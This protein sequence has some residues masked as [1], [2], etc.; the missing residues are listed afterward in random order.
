MKTVFSI[1][2]GIFM[3]FL[4]FNAYAVG[5]DFTTLTGAIDFSTLITAFMTVFGAM[6][7]V[8][9]V[10]KGGGAIAKRLGFG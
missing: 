7:A 6:I 8:G 10:V 9:I 1:I 3:S 5:P 2:F 4:G